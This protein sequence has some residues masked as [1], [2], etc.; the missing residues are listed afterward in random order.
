MRRERSRLGLLSCYESDESCAPIK[1]NACARYRRPPRIESDATDV[2]GLVYAL[3]LDASMP[4]KT[5]KTPGLNPLDLQ[6]E[7]SMAYE[8][9]ASGAEMEGESAERVP[10]LFRDL[11]EETS[12]ETA[13]QKSLKEG[14]VERRE[15]DASVFMVGFAAGVLAAFLVRRK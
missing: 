6:R 12:I 15:R 2:P 14:A 9:G 4:G 11:N 10:P 7:A 3:L 1:S 8:G 5:A 13:F